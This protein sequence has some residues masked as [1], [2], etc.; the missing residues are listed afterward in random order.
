MVFDITNPFKVKFSTY[1]NNR[2]FDADE[3][4]PDNGDLGVEGLVFVEAKKSP[5][6]KPLLITTNEISGTVT[7][8][9]ISMK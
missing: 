8:F 3:Q 1:I 2:N 7:I 5:T 6:K 9:Q 4:S